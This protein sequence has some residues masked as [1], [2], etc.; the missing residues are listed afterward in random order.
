VSQPSS[1]EQ[2][3][4][5]CQRSRPQVDHLIAGPDGV[6]IC[7]ECVYL[8]VQLLEQET[9]PV[10]QESEFVIE[11]VPSPK[12]LFNAL[13]EYVIGQERAKRVL[14]VAVHN[15]YKRVAAAARSK[16]SRS[17]RA[18]SCSSAPTGCGKTLLA[19]TLARFL[20]VPICIADATALT[21]AGL[22]G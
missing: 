18:T 9:A 15:H 12:E 8:S 3:C 4:S 6:F 11:H 19:Q 22:R 10:E 1:G 13:N 14:S 7:N 2:R 17:R 5:F 21:E 20:D 16:A